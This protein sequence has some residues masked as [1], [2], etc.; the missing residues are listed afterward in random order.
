MT[1]D[2]EKRLLAQL[3]RYGHFANPDAAEAMDA[4]NRVDRLELTDAG[5]IAAVAS[6]QRLLKQTFDDLSLRHH[7][8]MGIVDGE[9]GPATRELI[10]LPR[11]GVPD[12]AGEQEANW[13]RDCRGKLKAARDFPALPGM[14]AEDTDRCWWGICNNWT[15]ALSDVDITPEDGVASQV[16]GKYDFFAD[17]RRLGGSTLAWH[18]LAQ[19]NCAVTLQGAW[20]NDRSWSLVFALT[21]GTHEFGHG[22]GLG[23]VRD[24]QALMYPVINS[25]A[26]SRRGYPNSTDLAQCRQLGYLTSGRPQPAGDALYRPRGTDAPPDDLPRD[27]KVS[28]T[29]IIQ[30]G[31][32]SFTIVPVPASDTEA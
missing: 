13:P 5:A 16:P 29:I 8:R 22:L 3:Q 27:W 2:D 19:N 9:V 14:S 28:G 31:G 10:E 26:R 18:Q 32:Q 12:Y 25:A 21:T 23:H 7:G 20:D 15:A 24:G 4:A 6:Y 11:C 17:L 30:H 1:S